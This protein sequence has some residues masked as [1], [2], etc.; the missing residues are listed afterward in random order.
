M[1]KNEFW[2]GYTSVE[3]S[4]FISHV[5]LAVVCLPFYYLFPFHFGLVTSPYLFFLAIRPKNEYLLPVILHTLYGS[6]QRAF[7]ILACF[8]YV[9]FHFPELRRY[10]LHW[11]YLFYMLLLP[12]FIWFFWQKLSMPRNVPGVGDMVGGLFA[13]LLFSVA[14][15]ATLVVKK[16]GRPFFRGMVIWSFLLIVIM[17]VIG[18]GA[19]I[20][21]E[22]TGEFA[23]RTV[24]SRL[25]FWAMPFLSSSFIFCVFSKKHGYGLEKMLS[26]IGCFFI[27]LDFFHLTKCD[28]TFTQL[29]LVVFS[30]FVVYVALKWRPSVVVKFTLIPLFALSICV[31]LLSPVLVEK[32]G[33]INAGEGAYNDMSMTSLDS[34]LKKLQRKLVDDRSSVWMLTIKY[35]KRNI[36][37]N[38]IWV[39]PQPYMEVDVEGEI[40]GRNDYT[41]YL[42]VHSHNTMLSYIRFYGFYGGLGLYLLYLWYFCRKENRLV[43]VQCAAMPMCVVMAVCLAQGLIGGHTGFYVVSHAFSPVAFGCLGACWGE[44]HSLRRHPQL[45]HGDVR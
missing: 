40:K 23:D 9:L 22:G 41:L 36:M 30:A 33:G 15:W 2:A 20:D 42:S 32:Y 43:L 3:R 13:H 21:I 5:A 31:T 11:L 18:G 16:T 1:T 8:L 44:I 7:F 38:P 34:V 10:S 14:F 12:Y 45:W 24:F 35:I 25:I 17:S 37:P 19:M 28:V 27:L 39:K 29:G 6:Q 4:R 26:S